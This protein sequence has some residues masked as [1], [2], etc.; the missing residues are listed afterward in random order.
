MNGVNYRDW[1][2]RKQV[3]DDVI[4][5]APAQRLA[6]T[7][8]DLE[9]TLKAGDPLPPLWHWIYF[10][11]DAPQ[12]KV[13]PDGHAQTGDFMPPIALP[14]RMF[15]GTEVDFHAPLPLGAEARLEA[16]V[17]DVQ[18]KTGKTGA[19]AF[20]TVRR[21]IFAG[22]TLALEERQSIVYRAAGGR[23]AAPEPR[24]LPAP[25]AGAWTREIR[26][27]PVLLF[28]YSALT[29]IGHRIHYDRP[30]ATE[31][32]GYPGLIVHGPLL[33]TLLIELVRRNVRRSVRSFAFR[34]AAPI[35]DTAAFRV[36]GELQGDSVRL[37]A[38]RCDGETVMQAEAKLA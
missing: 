4:A 32:E 14:R 24:P 27:D 38:L 9:T 30:Y 29:F 21:R 10:L 16:E 15:A 20:V 25:P 7:L 6:G 12:S 3:R 34:A 11:P 28:R 36:Q 18:E 33:A 19:L 23:T 5:L 37:A 1:I 31:E 17:T 13:A 8:D 26:A 35:F 22:S 2:G